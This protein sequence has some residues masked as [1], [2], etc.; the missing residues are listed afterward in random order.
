MSTK[1]L[2]DDERLVAE[3]AVAMYREVQRAMQAAPHGHGLSCT[4]AAVLEH[5]HAF[6]KSVLEQTV[7]AHQ[8]AQK[9][10]SVA[11]RASVVETLPSNTTR[12]KS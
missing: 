9:K 4:E 6:L 8:E 3:Q 1:I 7:S 5:G 11:G 10:G 2:T 12:T